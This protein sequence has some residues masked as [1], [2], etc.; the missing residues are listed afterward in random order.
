MQEMRQEYTM[1]PHQMRD[2]RKVC[3]A[4]AEKHNLQLL[5]VN[6]TSCGVQYP[7]GSFGHIYID[8][9]VEYLKHKEAQAS[10]P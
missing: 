10:A 3:A 8:E 4:F 2:W 7:D 9:M 5:F 1:A 6:E